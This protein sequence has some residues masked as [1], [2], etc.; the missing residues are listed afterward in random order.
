MSFLSGLG[1]MVHTVTG[2]A[3]KVLGFVKAP[4]DFI[5]KP[6]IGLANTLLDR[7]PFGIGKLVEPF[8]DAFLQSAVGFVAGG[9]LGGMFAMISG[10][11]KT[12]Q[13]VDTVLHVA[14]GVLNGGLKALPQEA[15]AN[16]QN[17]FAFAH[18]QT[19]FA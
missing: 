3:D 19:L 6:F 18:A 13:T 5:T 15:L 7:L 16:A 10:A 12:V 2:I 9:P 11:E 4:L 17:L 1:K 14:D 8:A